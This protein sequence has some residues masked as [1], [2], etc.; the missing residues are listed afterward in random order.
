MFWGIPGILL[1]LNE[2]MGAVLNEYMGTV[3]NEYMGTVLN[4]SFLLAK[5]SQ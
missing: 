4:D 5:M 1:G 3:L 2:Y